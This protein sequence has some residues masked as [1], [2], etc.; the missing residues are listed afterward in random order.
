MKMSKIIK[1]IER[2]DCHVCVV[3]EEPIHDDKIYYEETPAAPLEKA[4]ARANDGELPQ[5]IYRGYA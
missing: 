3:C 4:I 5:P 2:C 1:T